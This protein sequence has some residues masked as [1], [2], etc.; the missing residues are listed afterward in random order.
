MRAKGDAVTL[1]RGKHGVGGS[2]DFRSGAVVADQL[3]RGR[4]KVVGREVPKV[5]RV[6]AREGVDRLSRVTD[7]T[8]LL[9]PAEPEVEQG[10]LDRRHVLVFVDHEPLVLASYLGGYPLIIGQHP[11]GQQEDVLHVHPPL[12]TFDVLVGAEHAP[13]RLGIN[14]VDRATTGRG[15]GRV[16]LGV[17]VG[18]LG[19]L[20]LRG[21][22]AQG[23][24]IGAE[25]LATSRR[26]EQPDL[27]LDQLG[28]IRAV[29]PWPEVPQLSQ[30]RRVEGPRLDPRGAE[31]AQ[32]TTHLTGRPS[33]ERDGQDLGWHVD[34]ARHAVRDA[35]GDGPRLAGPRPGQD[36]HRTAQRL[37]HLALLGVK[38]GEQLIRGRHPGTCPSRSALT[39]CIPWDVIVAA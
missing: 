16:A 23:R 14:A 17:D 29:G 15:E 7:H 20:D 13:H 27:G 22:V 24:L 33:R 32:P 19:P 10:G 18:H 9:A 26:G 38:R 37:G 1:G 2:D 11:R 30:G 35:M 34:P 4:A 31:L 3:D 21:E 39:A 12:T 28:R 25:P 8:Q 6:R 36:P 5:R